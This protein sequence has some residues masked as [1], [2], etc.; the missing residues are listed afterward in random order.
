VAERTES[1]E[2]VDM[3]DEPEIKPEPSSPGQNTIE[4]GDEGEEDE[5]RV[6][7][8]KPSVDVTFKGAQ[9]G[10]VSPIDAE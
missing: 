1:P 3:D 9:N 7:D 2:L 8:F 5:M 6:K 4:V 10:L